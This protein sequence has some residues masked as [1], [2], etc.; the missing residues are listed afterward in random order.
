[1]IETINNYIENMGFEHVLDFAFALIFTI[2][3]E[4]CV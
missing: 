1:M 3:I 4:L 2:I